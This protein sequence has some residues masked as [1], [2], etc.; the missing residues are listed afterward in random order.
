MVV[1]TAVPVP[2]T[3]ATEATRA[4]PL[5]RPRLVEGT[6]LIGQYRDSG[7][8]EP[9][10]LVRR[11]D[12]QIV[13]LSRLLYLVV[14]QLDGR[15]DLAEVA[16][17]AAE[18]FG[19]SLDAEQVALLIDRRLRPAGLLAH[20][21]AVAVGDTPSPSPVRPDPL[22]FLR[23]RV[24]VVP[25]HVV[26]RIAGLFHL[27]Y[28]LPVLTTM[29]AAFVGLDLW[30]LADGALERIVPSLR[31]LV[32]QPSMTLAVILTLIL[33]GVVHECGHVAAC[34]FGGARPGAM[35]VGIYL[36]WPAMYSTVTEAY[37]LGRR[38][39]L[40]VDLGGV[41]FNAVTMA[42]LAAA[43]LVTGS[44]W[45][46]VALVLLH[47]DTAWQ[48]LPSIRLDGYYILSDLVGVPDSFSRLGPILRSIVPGREPHPRV[49][50]L[51]TRARVVVTLWVVVVIPCLLALLLSFV[52]TAPRVLPN[53]HEA[54]LRILGGMAAAWHG[55]RLATVAVGVVQ[56]LVLVMPW[57]G[58][59]LILGSRAR[60]LLRRARRP[61]AWVSR[62]VVLGAAA[63]L[64]GLLALATVRDVPRPAETP[65]AAP[66]LATPTAQ[67]GD[68]S[69]PFV[70][71]AGV[72]GAPD[73]GACPTVR[74]GSGP[75]ALTVVLAGP[76]PVR[77]RERRRE[78]GGLRTRDPR[79]RAGP[80]VLPSCATW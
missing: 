42:A 66:W 54:V 28:R 50:E 32:A 34:R 17:R 78:L 73:P 59:G 11:P 36:V 9:H 2:V 23:Y 3:E 56:V 45:V 12:G 14:A 75:D 60:R 67:L 24:R 44:P 64:V 62:A 68:P 63:G 55:G 29:L 22:L 10:F 27:M 16:S 52:A 25:E 48:F 43:H 35:G 7:F 80:E 74:F 31:T 40:R 5:E 41:Y 13:Q 77:D 26:W 19:R 72:D 69:P 47:L 57:L 65:E 1:A 58:L 37:R 6:E 71:L 38:G 61:G 18:A 53:L 33:A 70:P 30:L 51:T 49:R 4:R 79:Q 76:G 20:R 21:D 15:R 39:R 8:R 46:L